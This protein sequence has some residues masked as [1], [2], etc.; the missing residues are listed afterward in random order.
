MFEFQ[1]R[2]PGIGAAHE[3]VALD[4]IRGIAKGQLRSG[5]KLPTID[6]LA[7]SYGY[8]PS[9]IR[10]AQATLKELKL[11]KMFKRSQGTVVL[12][13]AQQRAKQHLRKLDRA[14]ERQR[15]DADVELAQPSGGYARDDDLPRD[16]L[17]FSFD[18]GYS[19][20]RPTGPELDAGKYGPDELVVDVTL[21]DGTVQSY[22]VFHTTFKFPPLPRGDQ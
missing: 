2:P 22:G 18:T 17:E 10:Q 12:P 1:T 11:I 7:K 6:A 20:R 14:E 13:G 15:P 9:V 8:G 16:V 4:L 21:P 3:H 5:G 19:P